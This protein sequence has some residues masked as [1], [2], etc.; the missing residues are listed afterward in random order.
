MHD[1]IF[2]RKSRVWPIQKMNRTQQ[3]LYSVCRHTTFGPEW[4]D[5]QTMPPIRAHNHDNDCDVE[6]LSDDGINQ[7]R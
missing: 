3:L 7:R 5:C 1:A 4:D 2:C 6:L